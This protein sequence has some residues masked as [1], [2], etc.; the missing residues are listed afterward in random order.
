[1]VLAQSLRRT[2]WDYLTHRRDS[3]ILFASVVAVWLMWQLRASIPGHPGLEFHL[4]MATSA[5]LMFGWASAFLVVCGA[6]TLM[7]HRGAVG[8]G[9]LQR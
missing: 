6:Q 1:V 2:P 4:L 3:N 5:T 9:K 8:L 7:G